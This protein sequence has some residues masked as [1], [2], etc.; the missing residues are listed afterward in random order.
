MLSIH[1]FN[2]IKKQLFHSLILCIILLVQITLFSAQ[3]FTISSLISAFDL[4]CSFISSSRLNIRLFIWA[5]SVFPMREFTAINILSKI[6]FLLSHRLWCVWLTL[7]FNCR[8]CLITSL[9]SSALHWLFLRELFNF[10][11]FTYFLLFLLPLI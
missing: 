2:F 4:T 5:Y 1:L 8:R 3:V 9:I 6:A 7:L 10:Q 11:L